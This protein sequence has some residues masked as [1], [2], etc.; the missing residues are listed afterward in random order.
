MANPTAFALEP[1]VPSSSELILDILGMLHGASMS[2]AQAELAGKAFGYSA[3]TMRATLS[4]LRS[5]EKLLTPQ[6]GIYVLANEPT[7]Q[8]Q[9]SRSWRA[10]I[11]EP[12]PWN[13]HWILASWADNTSLSRNETLTREAQLS[14][15]GFKKWRPQLFV[16]PDNLDGSIPAMRQRLARWPGTAQI[17]LSQMSE[18]EAELETQLFSLWAE[19]SADYQSLERMLKG[20][21]H[22]I[23]DKAD[24]TTAAEV[25]SLGRLAIKSLLRDPRLPKPLKQLEALVALGKEAQAYE[26]FGMTIWNRYLGYQS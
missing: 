9:F 15:Y 6:K 24:A 19:P 20:S 5:K 8:W 22:R 13:G 21:R 7:P 16:R 23:Q 25:L 4:R 14:R 18:A 17:T 10:H 3:A 26:Q 12:M 1:D 11:A 2:P